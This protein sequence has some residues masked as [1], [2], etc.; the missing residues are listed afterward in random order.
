M[1]VPIPVSGLKFDISDAI[2]AAFRNTPDL[3][4]DERFEGLWHDLTKQSKSTIE[5]IA[6]AAND[7]TDR[8]NYDDI[9]SSSPVR[10]VSQ[11]LTVATPN[12]GRLTRSASRLSLAVRKSSSNLAQRAVAAERQAEKG[13]L[14]VQIGFNETWILTTSIVLLELGFLM[15]SAVPWQPKSYEWFI[16]KSLSPLKIYEPNV[17]VLVHPTFRDAFVKWTL[18]TIV[19]PLVV[20]VILTFPDEVQPSFGDWISMSDASS[21]EPEPA[22]G[23]NQRRITGVT[24]NEDY[25]QA[26][27][28]RRPFGANAV[29]FTIARLAIVVLRGYVF[30]SPVSSRLK[31]GFE[32]VKGYPAVQVVGGV[33]TLLFWLASQIY[34]S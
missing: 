34:S 12:S 22:R 2:Q 32:S 8:V 20:S 29:S 23:T 3:R 6:D 19:I 27:D 25:N 21:P 24:R 16:S 4:L 7:L 26:Q 30:A 11:A 15:Y 1:G 10:A 9:A 13:L 14:T 17:S 18:M 5:A 31:W 33:S 28:R